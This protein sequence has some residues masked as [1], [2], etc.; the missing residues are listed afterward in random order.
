MEKNN[1][2]D[3]YNIFCFIDPSNQQIMLPHPV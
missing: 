3:T 1:Y 2:N